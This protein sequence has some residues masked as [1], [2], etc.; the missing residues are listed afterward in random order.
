MKDGKRISIFGLAWIIMICA[1]ATK[2]D[3][4]D[5]QLQ[6]KDV[7]SVPFSAQT[8]EGEMDATFAVCQLQSAGGTDTSLYLVLRF[9]GQAPARIIRVLEKA[10]S[11]AIETRS[12]TIVVLYTSG[13]N[14]TCVTIYDLAT[15][16][17]RFLE[18]NVIAWNDQGEWQKSDAFRLYKR[19]NDRRKHRYQE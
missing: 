3:E 18:T 12:A 10:H 4:T 15:G 11:P 5:A 19:L 6:L 1:Q 14:T 8:Q 7:C 2:A 17:P 16:L 13:A 9:A